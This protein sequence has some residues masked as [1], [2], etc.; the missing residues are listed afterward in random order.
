MWS[1]GVDGCHIVASSCGE[2]QKSSV[3]WHLRAGPPPNGYA[4]VIVTDS[5]RNRHWHA[6]HPCIL[7]WLSERSSATGPD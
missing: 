3:Y 4:T 1:D 6:A 5:C 7:S 2:L